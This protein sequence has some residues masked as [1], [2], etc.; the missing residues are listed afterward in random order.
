VFNQSVMSCPHPPILG[1]FES[2]RNKYLF[3]GEVMLPAANRLMIN[4]RHSGSGGSG[5]GVMRHTQLR[6]PY[7]AC[8]DHQINR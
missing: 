7:P 2:V 1:H 4:R 5:G 3:Q 6:R 8:I